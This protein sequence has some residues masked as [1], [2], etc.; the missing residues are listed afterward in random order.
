[1]KRVALI[2]VFA[3]LASLVFTP[4][5]A[6]AEAAKSATSLSLPVTGSGAGG[7]FIG[8]FDLQR[9]VVQ[10]G[11][12][13]AAGLLIGTLTTATG[14]VTTIVKNIT[15]P[16]TVGQTS[17]DILHLELGPLFLDLLGL[18]I[19]LN[20]IVLDIDAQAGPGNL[21]GNLLC[22]VAGLLDDPTGLARVLNSI[23]SIL[24]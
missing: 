13:S 17:C 18:Q 19:N 3:V 7:T 14:L 24:G 21:L 11:A 8:T 12:V 6:T 10:N 23:L 4:F 16:L 1:M 15:I 2:I 5:A 22:A 20:Q 9:F